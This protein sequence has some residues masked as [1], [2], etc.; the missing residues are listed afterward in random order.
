MA[1]RETIQRAYTA[2]VRHFM[3][4]GRAPHYTE[5]ATRLGVSPDVARDLQAAAAEASPACWVDPETHY[6]AS[7]APFSNVPTQTRI[8]VDGV[9]RWYGQ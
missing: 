4:T 2:T 8:S 6:I 5:L 9:E 7:W 3:E 1:D